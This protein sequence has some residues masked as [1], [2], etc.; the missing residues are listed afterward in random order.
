MNEHQKVV[1]ALI[2]WDAKQAKRDKHHNP[3][4]LALALQ[5]LDSIEE[6][7]PGASAETLAKEAL[8]GRCLDFVLKY[9][10]EH[11]KG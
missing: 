1:T 2:Q 6:E 10:S 8:N 5:A 7:M 4:F 3:R 11:W 9:I